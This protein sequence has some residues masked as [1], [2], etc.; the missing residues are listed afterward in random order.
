MTM[1]AHTYYII[2]GPPPIGG[3]LPAFPPGGATG[4][5]GREAVVS[6]VLGVYAGIWRI[7]T[8]GFF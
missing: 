2:F 5:R 7:P 8:S 1:K 4:Y 6:G 3:K